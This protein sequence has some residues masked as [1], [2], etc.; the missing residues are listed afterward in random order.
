MTHFSVQPFVPLC[1]ARERITSSIVEY[2]DCLECFRI[3]RE[4]I[5][6][7]EKE[8]ECESPEPREV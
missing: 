2:V 1:G 7:R 4:Q 6:E 5:D 8:I 3:L